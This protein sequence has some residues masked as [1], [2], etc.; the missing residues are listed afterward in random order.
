MI[1][2][3]IWMGGRSDLYIMNRDEASKKQ[4]YSAHSY[5][6]VLKNQLSTIWSSDL[7]FMQDNA[8]IHTAEVI[9]E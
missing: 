4:D 9:K 6:E 5:I 2:G 7:I 8:S 1:W 3:A